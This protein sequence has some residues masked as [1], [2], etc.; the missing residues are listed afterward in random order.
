MDSLI[1]F[2][3]GV[4]ASMAANYAAHKI[5][6]EHYKKNPNEVFD[7]GHKIF[8]QY[9]IPEYV[10]VLY[11]LAALSPLLI[12]DAATRSSVIKELLPK[13]GILFL[14]R[15]S[16]V[17]TTILPKSGKCPKDDTWDLRRMTAG[18]C[19][20]KIFSGHMGA[21]VLLALTFVKYKIIPAWIGWVYAGVMAVLILVTRGHYSVDLILGAAIAFLLHK[22]TAL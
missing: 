5:G 22:T 10:L 9:E 15:A 18:G 16:T 1:L 17:V 4:S 21:A 3:A 11:E 2:G 13:L 12:A 19:Y 14:L 20:D 8:M 7:V 6:T